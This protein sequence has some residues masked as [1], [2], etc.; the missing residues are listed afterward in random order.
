MRFFDWY[1]QHITESLI[2]SAVILYLQIPHT[3]TA[4]DCFFHLGMGV[5][6]ANPITDF[7]LYGID[8]LEMIPIISTT[9]A[10]VA[11]VRHNF[12]R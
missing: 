7:L 8:L 4:A 2:I 9:L 3:L 11:K 1:E 5:F 6:G 12:F 10:I